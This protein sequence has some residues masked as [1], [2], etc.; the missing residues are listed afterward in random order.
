[1][2]AENARRLPAL[3]DA[4]DRVVRRFA[5]RLAVAD[6]R[7]PPVTLARTAAADRDVVVQRLCADAVPAH[8][9]KGCPEEVIGPLLNA[10]GAHARSAGVTA[11]RRAGRPDRAEPFLVDRSALVRACA[12]Y[13]LRQHGDD[14]P[15]R[16]RAWCADAARL[17]L[18]P[19]AAVGLAECG[20][21][22]D[23]ALLWP[24]V[25][26]PDAA[27]RARAVTGLRLLDAAD[28]SRLW[29]LLADEAPAVAREAATALLPSALAVP[30]EWLSRCVGP[31]RPVHTRKAACRLL[32]AAGG[33]ERLR[34]LRALADDPDERI[35]ARA[36]SALR[37]RRV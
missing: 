34:T 15:S 17:D 11:L 37:L 27:V 10:R 13:V 4:D 28:A 26:H 7:L 22:T 32:L 35:R 36:R 5:H 18:P 8:V 29:P 31:E 14:P 6:G 20:R 2:R 30:M 1:M 9:G 21:R 19:W 16:Y 12:R 25:G 3:L 33:A 23:A 24:L